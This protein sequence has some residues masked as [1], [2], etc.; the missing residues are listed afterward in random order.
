MKKTIFIFSIILIIQGVFGQPILKDSYISD[1]C[2]F[3]VHNTPHNNP[4]GQHFVSSQVVVNLFGIPE[5]GARLQLI[6]AIQLDNELDCYQGDQQGQLIVYSKNPEQIQPSLSEE[7]GMLVKQ[8]YADYKNMSKED[9]GY[10]L[11]EWKHNLN[12]G[13]YYFAIGDREI[14]GFTCAESDPFCTSVVYSFPAAT[15]GILEPGPDYGCLNSDDNPVWYHMRIKQAGDITIEMV[16][17]R[18]DGTGLDI[19]FALWGPYGDPI[20][21]CPFELTSLCS[22]TPSGCP[23]NTSD[24]TFY[25]SGNLHDCSWSGNS[26]EYA[27]I[28]NGLVGQYYIL[29]ILNYQPNPG[30]ITFQKIAGDGET[31][32]GIVPPQVSNNG[33]LCVGETLELYATDEPGA[34]YEWTG[35][36]GFTSNDQNPVIPNVTLAHAGDYQVIVTLDGEVSDPAI[37][38][39]VIT[40]NP[41]PDFSFLPSSELC[42][43]E[44]ISFSGV[45]TE[46]IAQWDWDFGDGTT[47]SGQNPTHAYLNAGTK[48][49]SLT[50]TTVGNCSAQVSQVLEV[51]P[52]PEAV[53]TFSTTA[54]VCTGDPIN[55]TG[56]STTNIVS[57]SWDFGD[58]VTATGQSVS[59]TFTTPG[60]HEVSLVVVNSNSCSDEVSQLFNVSLT[61]TVDFTLTPGNTI[62][63]DELLTMTGL[64][65]TPIVNWS[66]DFGDGNTGSGQQVDHGYSNF[67]MKDITLD[68]LSDQNC[69]ASVMHQVEVFETPEAT[70]TMNTGP[71]SCVGYLIS[72]TG[73]ATT[74]MA[75]WSWDFGD[76]HVANGSI[77]T[78]AYSAPGTYTIRL[79]AETPD[80]CSDTVYTQLIINQLPMADF[81]VAPNDTVCL[82]DQVSFSA[83]GTPDIVTWNWNFGDG[84]LATGQSVGYTYGNAGVYAVHS[85]YTND[86]GCT[87]TTTREQTVIDLSALDFSITPS[88]T[89]QHYTVDFNGI[90]TADFTDWNWDFGDGSQG[91]GHDVSHVYTSPDTLNVQLDVCIESVQKELIVYPICDVEAGSIQYTCQDVYFDYA[92]AATPPTADGY[93]SVQ[94]FTTGLGYFDDPWA[95]TPTY[96][97]HISEGAV[98]NDTLLMTMIGYGYAPCENDTSYAELVVIPGAFAY[99]GSDENVC[100]GESFDFNNS[101]DSAFATNYVTLYWLTN[102]TGFFVDSTAMRPTYVPGIGEIGPITMTMVASNIISCDS[103]DEMV[104]TIRPIYEM[105]V[106]TTICFYD[107]LYLQGAW[108]TQSGIYID[109]VPTF[110]YGCDSV[111]VTNLTVRPKIDHD[112]TMS[113]PNPL[114]LEESITFTPT[115][116]A[117]ITDRFWIFGDGATST[118][119][120]PT[121]T[122]QAPGTYQLIYSYTDQNGCS[123]SIMQMITVN[124]LPEV[125]YNA[126]Q[127]MVC[128]GVPITFTGASPSNIVSWH[129]D[130]DD[131]QTG[132]G[133]QVTH[134]FATWG[135]MQ[136]V[137]TVEDQNGCTQSTVQTIEVVQPPTADF[138]YTID[139]C[140]TAQFTDLSTPP[141]GYYLVEWYWE[142]GDDSTSTWP[143]PRHSY[144]TGGLYN[145]TLTVTADSMG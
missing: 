128:L 67:G 46:T 24:P 40:D 43:N 68:V 86:L 29:V 82:G 97:P 81:L 123:D 35:P 45:S 140:L 73:T 84:N 6:N 120:S 57:W 89:C 76:M 42:V 110:Y 124:P 144:L 77:V 117:Q 95:V 83:S 25:P 143:N 118:Q 48:N 33:P 1:T 16:G 30:N 90:G 69:P 32:C 10:A 26:I 34:T 19:D 50:V 37:T 114:C 14:K 18:P 65:D 15:S 44:L 51:F 93:A 49:V 8:L 5:I 23:N 21:P 122:Y 36:L 145:V 113:T 3:P 142:F 138:T 56:S 105:N 39:V 53:M 79:I 7:L 133:Q 134:D 64:S 59:H 119:P 115:G 102:G 61:P 136:V 41:V 131:G 60:V 103:I 58:G 70:I 22:A 52:L 112:F 13:M 111:I 38:N 135:S 88:P 126:S 99:A 75:L 139:S 92:D 98:Q 71:T 54:D 20:T 47:A 4:S 78:H 106:N 132:T 127:T 109:T 2:V 104:L 63:S 9:L 31:D 66:W 11:Q 17:T 27:H 55:F 12:E 129:W 87:D 62:C 74:N 80:G 96:F 125:S 72:F 141:P 137:L 107:S 121:H 100:F 130:F 101:V 91:L 28:T 85:I 108:Q 116:T 94:W